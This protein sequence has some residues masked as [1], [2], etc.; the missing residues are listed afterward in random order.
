MPAGIDPISLASSAT[1]FG[2]GALQSLIGGSKARKAQ[3]ALQNLQ[4]PTYN[5]S[6]SIGDYYNQALQ[7]Y[8]T[9]PY[10]SQQYQYAI[11]NAQRNQ[12]AGINALQGRNSAVGGISRLVALGNDSA[13]K[14]G[15]QAEQEQ[16]Q[17]FNQL[18][19]AAGLQANQD[20]MAFQYNK[21][22]PYEK[23]YNLLSAKAAGNNQTTNA[24]ISNMFGALGSIQN[25]ALAN[26]IYGN[27]E[28]NNIDNGNNGT[29][30][31]NYYQARKYG[32][33]R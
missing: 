24:G 7:R 15:V 22:A 27:N 28:M 17:R 31:P 11:Q 4:T 13:Q 23:Q 26:K 14:A 1:Q 18:G 5:E 33:L 20:Q 25:D 3:N 2:I 16:N 8:N 6:K 19:N 21:L 10:Q 29:Y 30:S 9:N 12:A 32:L